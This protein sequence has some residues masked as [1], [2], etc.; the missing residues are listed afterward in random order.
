MLTLNDGRAELWQWDTG[1]T[2][3]VDADCSQVHFSNKV[4]GRSIDV[5]VTDGAAIIPDILLQTDKDLNVWAFVGA[6]ENGYTKI[7]KTFKVNRRNKPADYVFTP[8]EQMTIAEIAAI[9]QSVRNDAD[10]G[11]FDGAQGPAG[12]IGP[13]GPK[14]ERGVQ[15]EKGDPGEQGPQGERGPQG[16]KGDDAVVD[17]TLTQS[18]Q[19]ADAQAVGDKFR[20]LSEEKANQADVDE[21]KGDL[22]QHDCEIYGI[23]AVN[24]IAWEQGS[25]QNYVD[26]GS[27][28][29]IRTPHLAYHT[30]GSVTIKPESGYKYY[31]YLY[32]KNDQTRAKSSFAWE[33]DSVTI[34]LTENMTIRI[35]GAKSDDS[36][37]T[38]NDGTHIKI[39]SDFSRSLNT[40]ELKDLR[41]NC[42]EYSP[43]IGSLLL[44]GTPKTSTTRV[45]TDFFEVEPN[46]IIGV[47]NDINTVQFYVHLFDS[48]GTR[49]GGS[50]E[51]HTYKTFTVPT[52][53]RV[54]IVMRYNNEPTI[55]DTTLHTL[56]QSVY[57]RNDYDLYRIIA[58][59]KKISEMAHTPES[60][61]TEE[62]STTIN[63]A[64]SAI[65]EKCLVFAVLTDSHADTDIRINRMKQTADNIRAVGKTVSFDGIIHMGDILTGTQ[66]GMPKATAM[67]YLQ[68]NIDILK[69][70]GLPLYVVSG[71]HD[72]NSEGNSSNPN[73]LISDA[74][75]YAV[76][77]RFCDKDVHRNGITGDFYK[78]F[79]SVEIRCIWLYGII[80]DYTWTGFNQSQID[81]I[82]SVMSDAPSSYKF[83]V[84]SHFPTRAENNNNGGT[85]VRGT[86]LEEAIAPYA[87]RMIAFI[88]GHTHGDKIATSLPY[89]E[90]S[91]CCNFAV[92]ATQT[93]PEG[94]VA[95]ERSRRTVTQDCWDVVIIKE[96]GHINFV[97]FGAGSDRAV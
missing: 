38:P 97:R 27:S 34:F 12:P 75:R 48:E 37:I 52:K 94:A 67:Q 95:P 28:T 11:L 4:F 65:D 3:A 77:G 46:T 8:V 62:V 45:V 88:H 39:S 7:S 42:D 55:T 1:R 31:W 24:S 43:T 44:D 18:G 21:L 9:A 40:N 30:Y 79:D 93:L 53:C 61:F 13:V 81:W 47:L 19:A 76:F 54:R 69:E 32:D 86:A 22:S 85:V 36:T 6:A 20:E 58:L 68:Q 63:S 60:Y 15:G 5:D 10:A 49:I 87:D 25:I 29:R 96:S 26:A 70:I 14:G 56:A 41:K 16:E 74:D 90:I 35:V 17:A 50:T 84:F 33:T 78:D 59:D 89:P 91:I 82:S 80:N 71:N 23:E 72:D 64:M 66:E 57:V 92:Q 83:V 2:L 51:W 73:N